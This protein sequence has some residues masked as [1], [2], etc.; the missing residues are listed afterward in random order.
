MAKTLIPSEFKTHIID[1]LIES[2]TESANTVYY[3]F[4]GDHIAAGATE[5]EVDQPVQNY[6]SIQIQTYRNMLIGK[7]MSFDDIKFMIPRYDWETGTVYEMYD[8]TVTNLLDKNFFVCVDE[9]AYKHVYKC[10]Y[11]ANGAQSTSKP[12]FKDAQYDAELYEEGDAYYETTDGYQWKYMYSIDS[13]TFSKFA[14]QK[15][16][17]VTA[18]TTI[19]ANASEGSID[20]IRV[21][22]TGKNYRNSKSGQF[23]AEDFNRITTTIADGAG[24]A[25]PTLWYRIREASQVE[26]F[27]AN[28]VMYLTSGTGSGEYRSVVQSKYVTGVGVVVKIEQQW[29]LA[30]DDTTTY[31]L[32]PEVRITGN[33]DES[34]KAIARAVINTAAADSIDRIEMLE[35]GRGYTYAVADVLIG[36]PADEDLEQSGVLI[37]TTPAQLRPIIS[38]QGGHGANTAVEL[39]AKHLAMYMKFNRDETGLI[40]TE[41]TFGQFGIVRDPMYAN[42]EIYYTSPTGIFIEDEDVE[43]FI[44]LKLN[45]TFNANTTLQDG[46]FVQRTDGLEDN[47]AE[48]FDTGDKI[49]IKN[50]DNTDQVFMTEVAVGSNTTAIS[51]KDEIAFLVDGFDFNVEVFR[52]KTVATAKITN[53]NPPVA[54]PG[55]TAFLCDKVEPNFVVGELVYGRTSRVVAE[56]TGIDINNRI[57]SSTATF[58]FADYNQMLKIQGTTT[59][60]LEYNEKVRQVPFNT[61]EIQGASPIDA[62]GFIH[63]W[64]S[65]QINLTRVE[66][67]FQSGGNEI[68]GDNSGAVFERVPGDNFDITYGDLDPNEGSIIYIQNDIPVSREQNQSEEIRV[69]LEF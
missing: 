3:A 63:S 9:N 4:I 61:A 37:E 5:E 65:D 20:V 41:N 7:R 1:Q 24:I 33:G 21:I 51:L 50:A 43:Q 19:E 17:P 31:E 2:V 55:A 32:S 44:P 40:A 52:S 60:T 13:R 11:N 29:T 16:I 68:T 45:G 54:S 22:S 39:G 67:D 10:L 35:N 56:V 49:Y 48:F 15:Y 47:Y 46:K 27:Y 64:T 25:D 36:A 66:G 28:T 12:L 57:N 18:N 26:N 14:T 53:T 8:D 38:P 59:D 58:N 30:P 23:I 42:V 62:T 69:I 6:N 34:V